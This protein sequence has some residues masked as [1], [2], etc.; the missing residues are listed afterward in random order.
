MAA[1]MF[2][3]MPF[4]KQIG[5]ERGMIVGFTS[6]FLAFLL[7]FFGVRS[8]RENVGGGEISFLRALNVGFLIMA[9]GTLCYVIAWEIVYF[10]F[11]PDFFEKYSAYYLQKMSA[12]GKSAQ[13]IEAQRRALE[14]AA[15]RYKNP[16]W[17]AA[18]TFCEPLPVGI[19]VSL[20]SALI[21]RRRHKTLNGNEQLATS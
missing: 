6:M 12:A 18:Y 4:A 10:N 17:N 16:L 5:F 19:P 2:G 3:T 9:V 21:L 7:I 11:F 13:E 20:I 15:V 1:M 14:V 8:Y